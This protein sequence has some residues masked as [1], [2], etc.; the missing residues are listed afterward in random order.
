VT[1][2]L[3]RWLGVDRLERTVAEQQ[4]HLDRLAAAHHETR[5]LAEGEAAPPGSP[6]A[7]YR[8]EA[9]RIERRHDA[10]TAEQVKELRERY[11]DPVFGEVPVWSLVEKLAQCI[12][13]SD[14]RLFGA[15]QQVH[16]LQLIEAMD[17]DGVL[18]DELLLVALIHDLGKVLLLTDEDPANIVAMNRPVGDHD[19][20]IGL[21]HATLQWNHDELAW[22]RFRDLVPEHVAWLVRYHSI[23]LEACAPLMDD[24]DRDLADRYLAPFSHYDHDFKSPFAL[25]RTTIATYRDV[26]EDAFPRPIRF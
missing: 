8:A 1:S 10:Q 6:E 11:A 25:P 18:T 17:A 16:V 14:C 7:A 5:M 15:S 4:E 2:G 9:I 23:D 21:D 13:P 19:D 12:D 22:S 26:V 20:G 24:R 3:R